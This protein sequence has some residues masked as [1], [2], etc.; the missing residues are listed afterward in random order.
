MRL[1]ELYGRARL[2]ALID[3]LTG[4][5]NHRAFQEELA[6]Q[7]EFAVRSGT[8]LS[9]LLIDVDD[10]KRVNDEQGMPTATSSCRRSVA[11]SQ[12]PCVATTEHSGWW[13]TSSRSCC[14]ARIFDT[15][16]TVA[17]R[18]LAGALSGGDGEFEEFPVPRKHAHR[19][20]FGQGIC[21]NWATTR[22]GSA[23]LSILGNKPK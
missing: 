5:G 3:G 2:D 14:L 6:R 1:R 12:A 13:G 21:Q 19:F 11:R 8:L 18:I 22:V 16:L 20:Q 15:G 23:F 7:L 10:L 4:L 17:R 9:L